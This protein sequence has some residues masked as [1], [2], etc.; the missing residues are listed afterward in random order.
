MGLVRKRIRRT[1]RP[2]P[3]RRRRSDRPRHRCPGPFAASLP[4]PDA[5]RHRSGSQPTALTERAARSPLSS[6][7]A[8]SS[9]SPSANST[10]SPVPSSVIRWSS[11]SRT[12]GYRPQRAARTTSTSRSVSLCW[13][14]FCQTGP[15]SAAWESRSDFL[16]ELTRDAVDSHLHQ[17]TCAL[18]LAKPMQWVVGADDERAAPVRARTHARRR[19]PDPRRVAVS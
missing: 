11:P 6:T 19:S 1:T 9:S 4:R 16:S 8:S 10:E 18:T 17:R 15:D 2:R 3:C 7:R 5:S 14:T 12:T 13:T